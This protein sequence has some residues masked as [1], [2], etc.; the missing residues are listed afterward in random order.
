LPSA[1]FEEYLAAAPHALA[2]A[3]RLS[4]DHDA[5]QEVSSTFALAPFTVGGDA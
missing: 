2:M 4:R 1:I 3:G 5:Y